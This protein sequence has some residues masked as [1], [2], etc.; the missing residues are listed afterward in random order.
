M[1]SDGSVGILDPQEQIYPGKAG[2]K[3]ELDWF[4]TEPQYSGHTSCFL[5]YFN[6]DGS[7]TY[8]GTIFRFPLR[9]RESN[10]QIKPDGLYDTT[11]VLKTLFE[12]L[13]LEASNIL[14]FLK[15]V[16]SIQLFKKQGKHT[17]R[18]FSV[19]IPGDYVEGVALC[20]RQLSD[21]VTDRK[22]QQNIKV[23]INVFPI[24]NSDCQQNKV[25][26]VLNM[27]GFPLSPSNFSKFYQDRKLDYLP[28][29]G[30][31][32]ETGVLESD[33]NKSI[34]LSFQYDW[35][36]ED[37]L[38]FINRILPDLKFRFRVPNRHQ[39][40]VASGKLFCF[41]P[42]PELSHLPVNF[43]G[44]FA[45][46]NN[47]RGIKWPSLDSD[48]T[49]S[50][51]NK[52]LVENIGVSAYA[53]FYRVLIHGFHHQTPETYHYRL[54]EKGNSLPNT[55]PSILVDQGLEKLAKS[56]IVY[57]TVLNEWIQVS[58]GLYHPTQYVNIIYNCSRT[59]T[60]INHL[61]EFLKLPLVPLPDTFSIALNEIDTI[62]SLIDGKR[63]TPKAIREILKQSSD[64]KRL[65]DYF[66][67]NLK[68]DTLVILAFIL[69]DLK[70][71]YTHSNV[72]LE[73][74]PLLVT[75]SSKI[76]KFSQNSKDH[77]YIYQRDLHFIDLFPGLEDSFVSTDVPDEI[78]SRLLAISQ[79]CSFNLK[80]ISNCLRTDSS[81]LM[82][83]FQQS[84]NSTFPHT[85]RT[86]RWEPEASRFNLEWIKSVWSFLSSADKLVRS[87]ETLPLLPKENLSS[88]IN[89]LL[90]IHP[91]NN[92]N[93]Y[94][95]YSGDKGYSE[96]ENALVASGAIFIYHNNRLVECLE[97]LI[98]KQL[99]NGFLVLLEKNPSIL[100]KFISQLNSTKN[101]SLNTNIIVDVLNRQSPYVVSQKS[102]IIKKLPIFT[103]MSG[104]N[105]PLSSSCV[106]VP[107]SIGLPTGI[108]YP[109][110]F[111]SPDYSSLNCLYDSLVVLSLDISSFVIQHL[112]TFMQSLSVHKNY[113]HHWLLG[114]WLLDRMGNLSPDVIVFLRGFE[115]IV[116]NSQ[117]SISQCGD[118]KKPDQLFYPDDYI[119]SHILPARSRFFPHRE[120]QSYSHTAKHSQ[121]F[122]TSSQI[123]N[124]QIFK[125]IVETAVGNF[126]L[127]EEDWKNRFS[128][129]LELLRISTIGI[130]CVSNSLHSSAIALP[131]CERPEAYPRSLPFIGVRKLCKLKAVVFCT[132]EEV[133]LIA[134]VEQC[135]PLFTSPY[136]HNS[137]ANFKS[138]LTQL[139]CRTSL[140]GEMLV[141]QLNK[142][143]QTTP[144]RSDSQKLHTL[145]NAIY[146]HPRMLNLKPSIVSNFVYVKTRNMFVDAT[147]IVFN[148]DFSLE[149]HY[150]SFEK[151]NYSAEAG[152]LFLEQGAS[153]AISPHQ[154]NG[155]LQGLYNAQAVVSTKDKGIV[156]K[157]I[158]YLFNFEEELSL[159]R[160][161]LLG[162]DYLVHLATE[163]VFYSSGNSGNK[164]EVEKDNK[165]YFVVHSKIPCTV[166]TKFGAKSLKLT[167]LGNTGSIFECVGQY[168]HLTTRLRSILKDY[169]SSI[170]V[171]KELIQNADDAKANYV[172]VLIDYCTFPAMSL[173]EPS[174]KLWQGP[175]LYF[176]N[177]AEFTDKDFLNILQI[178]GETKLH[179]KCKIGKFGLGFNT[180]YHLTDLP[181]FVS[182]RYIY[183]LDPHRKYLVDENCPPGIRVD[184]IENNKS[185]L[186]YRDQFN[187]FNF[188]LFNCNVFNG[189]PFKGTLFRLPFRSHHVHS[190][191]SS[192]VYDNSDITQLIVSIKEQTESNILFLQH[193]SRIEVYQRTKCLKE[194]QLLIVSKK[195]ETNPFPKHETFISQNLNHFDK[196]VS[197]SAVS[198]VF[199]FQ[200][201]SIAKNKTKRRYFVSYSTGTKQCAE[202]LREI[203]NRDYTPAASIAIPEDTAL[204]DYADT[205]CRSNIYC[206]LPLPI[207]S[208][209]PM[210][211]NGCFAL[212][213]SRRA[214]AC[215]EDD[216]ERTK[217]NQALISDALV[218]ALINLLNQVKGK[219]TQKTISQFYSLW[220]LHQQQP[221]AW[222]EFPHSFAM[223]LIELNIPLFHYELIANK[224]ISYQDA[225][226]FQSE[227][228]YPKNEMDDFFILI[229]NLVCREFSTYL[230]QLPD[231]VQTS[232]LF[233]SFFKDS[234]KVYSL[235]EICK[236]FVFP[237]FHTLSLEQIKLVLTALLPI[238]QIA[239]QNWI[240]KLF[241]ETNCIPCGSHSNYTLL[242]PSSVVSSHSELARLYIPTDKRTIHPDLVG[243]FAKKSVHFKV[244][245]SLDMI[246]SVLPVED[247]IERCKCQEYFV[248]P[249]RKEHC[250]ILL[251]YLNSKCMEPPKSYKIGELNRLKQE[252]LGIHFIPVWRD[253]LLIQL[254][255]Q[256]FI[257]FSTPTKCF[258]YNSRYF[259]PPEYYSAIQE[260]DITRLNTFLN[261]YTS[262]NAITIDMIISLL[263]CLQQ[264]E[265][266][267]FQLN[268]Q[269]EL[270]T[271]AAKIYAE[272][273]NLWKILSPNCKLSSLKWIWH[274]DTGCF[275]HVSSMVTSNKY[276]PYK[277][278]FLSTFPYKQKKDFQIGNTDKFLKELGI[279][280]D[281]N[282]ERA[283]YVLSQIAS[284]HNNTINS[285]ALR[286]LIIEI[287]NSFF[288][289]PENS[290]TT[291]QPV[292][293]SSDLRL[294][295]PSDLRI[296]DMPWRKGGKK[297][298]SRGIP[299]SLV[300]YKIHPTA[301]FNLGASSIRSDCFTRE[302]FTQSDFGQHEDIADRINSLKRGFPCGTTILK[303]LLQNAEDAGASE[304]AFVLDLK[305]YS[306]QTNSLCFSKQE[307]PHWHKYQQCP[308]LLVYNNS[309]FSKQD[310]KGIQELGL[311]GKTD[312]HTIGKF[313]L[314]F[315]AVYHLTDSPC[316]LTR[317]N[318]DKI[319]SFCIF[320]PFRKYL[321]LDPGDRPGIH[322]NFESTKIDEFP[323]QFSPYRLESLNQTGVNSFPS[324][325]KGDY[326]LF[327][328]PLTNIKTAE[329]IL[330]AFQL[331]SANMNLFLE[332]IKHISIYKRDKNGHIS[333]LG[334][335]DLSI[336]PSGKVSPLNSLQCNFMK[337]INISVREVVI[338]QDTPKTNLG[339][340][341]RPVSPDRYSWL[342]LTHTG[343]IEE[344][345]KC[346]PDIKKYKS[347]YEKE[348][349]AH[350]VYGGI[351][352]R[353]PGDTSTVLGSCLYSY[354]PIGDD[355]AM[356]F[357]VV[358]NAP[359]ILEPER[360]HIRFKDIRG[361]KT[362]KKEWEDTWHSAIIEHVLT[363]LFVS[364]VLYLVNKNAT[365]L[366]TTGYNDSAY[367]S[368]Y[369]SLYPD[370]KKLVGS[371]EIYNNFLYALCKHF[372]S[373]LYK[374]N[375]RVLIDQTYKELYSLRGGMEGVFP[376]ISGSLTR[377]TTL[378]SNYLATICADSTRPTKLPR[379][380]EI[381][382]K[383]HTTLMKIQFR[384]AIA[385]D[386]VEA[387]F[388]SFS[389]N[390]QRLNQKYLLQF[391]NSNI[392]KFYNKNVSNSLLNL[393]DIELLLTYLLKAN[394]DVLNSYHTIPLK[395]DYKGRFCCFTKQECT[396]TSEYADLLPDCAGRF[397]YP[398]FTL[399]CTAQLSKHGFIQQLDV[400]FLSLKLCK[401]EFNMKE[402]CLFWQF[403]MASSFQSHE[404]IK[405]FG[406]F[407]CIPVKTKSTECLT[408]ISHLP[409][410]LGP[411]GPISQLLLLSSLKKLNCF[412]L[413]LNQFN[414]CR[415]IK[416]DTER[417]G[418]YL[419]QLTIGNITYP[420]FMSAVKLSTIVLES[421][422]FSVSEANELTHLFALSEISY[423][424]Y[425]E[426]Q[427]ISKLK[428]FE[429]QQL[430]LFSVS[431]FRNCF[432]NNSGINFGPLL[433]AILTRS[434]LTI[435]RATHKLDA[436][437]QRIT[438]VLRINMIAEEAIFL[439][440]VIPHFAELDIKEQQ[441][442]LNY[443]ES[444]SKPYK[445]QFIARLRLVKFIRNPTSGV[446]SPVSE[447]YC[448]AVVLFRIFFTQQ[449]LP[450]DWSHTDEKFYRLLCAVGLHNRADLESILMA[451]QM[452]A[453]NTIVLQSDQKKLPL[454]SLVTL[455]KNN[456]SLSIGN[457]SL[458][459]TLS[460]V[461]FLP[462]WKCLPNTN[463]NEEHISSFNEAE[464]STYNYTCCTAAYIHDTLVTQIDSTQIRSYLRIRDRP[465]NQTVIK[466]LEIICQYFPQLST[467]HSRVIK[468]F[469]LKTYKFLQEH[470]DQ[471]SVAKFQTMQCIL[472]K[473]RL[474]YPRNIVFSLDTILMDYLFKVPDAF[475]EYHSF[476]KL[477]GVAN[478]P[479][480]LHYAAVLSDISRDMSLNNEKRK[481]ISRST[482]N[483]FICSLR[484]AEESGAVVVLDLA[485]TMV[486]SSEFEIVKLNQVVY[487][488][489]TRLKIHLGYFS[490]L[491]SLKFLLELTPNSLGS[492]KP[493]VAFDVTQLSAIIQEN[494][495][496]SLVRAPTPTKFKNESIKLSQILKSIEF[497]KGLIRI[498]YHSTKAKGKGNLGFIR[499]NSN[500]LVKNILTEPRIVHDPQFSTVFQI[501]Q[502]LT[503]TLLDSISLQI[504][505][506]RSNSVFD[507]DDIYYCYIEESVLYAKG[508]STAGV[509]FFNDLTYALNL[510]LGNLFSDML[511]ALQLCLSCRNP[512][513]IPRNLD[514]FDI[515][516]C[517]FIDDI[518]LPQSISVPTVVL[519]SPAPVIRRAAPISGIFNISGVNR[520][521]LFQ[522]INRPL[523]PPVP[524]SPDT[525]ISVIQSPRGTLSAQDRFTAKLWIRTAQCDLLAAKKL[526]CEDDRNAIFPPHSCANCFECAMKTCIAIL[527]INRLQEANISCQRNLDILLDT[528]KRFFPSGSDS[529]KK[530]SCNCV[531]LMN[532]DEN[533]KNPLM[534]PGISCCLPMEQ[535]S[536]ATAKEAVASASD[537]LEIV[538]SQ[539]P[540]FNELMF[541]EGD[542]VWE[543]P[544][545]RSLIMSQLENCKL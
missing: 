30:I 31:A 142:I 336:T 25:M 507:K 7:Y 381:E 268:L 409:G 304:I 262:N 379:L 34:E 343:S 212:D 154:L 109:I 171:Y 269:T 303:E 100:N 316:L 390:L 420:A 421:V 485:N 72:Y 22:F 319:I 307:Q 429:S 207:K 135:V 452:I 493:P 206:Y 410:I 156:I 254:E 512:L 3:I 152:E 467:N 198:P 227:Q 359:F 174:M 439:D 64:N 104:N 427:I 219:Y 167:L 45:L 286:D 36:G 358:I 543:R 500:G 405:T 310:L 122:L 422:N 446:E 488:D 123:P 348:K 138:I 57:S 306:S 179:D 146:A 411:S 374:C 540:V 130:S 94:I 38:S 515:S 432:I 26:L 294:C 220:P 106:R 2:K 96:L 351:A 380:S 490:D 302:H 29:I 450:P 151:L 53:I 159:D 251:N 243:L 35:N 308:S 225:N 433:I 194:L 172:R 525:P 217:W 224:W 521:T 89:L 473:D 91:P 270:S 216:S 39:L 539:F 274:P 1:L 544:T 267:I 177:D 51:W 383:L 320:D 463:R 98:V 144:E 186:E 435:F 443:V 361:D 347:T 239:G 444:S 498:Y 184:F 79:A 309:A 196:L 241:S 140:T 81:L 127:R 345:E 97:S 342:L 42:T 266:K 139:G 451:A 441:G 398:G 290:C 201:I 163:C 339:K 231:A 511:F 317:R 168:E 55:L 190:L 9:T 533:A 366:Q 58:Q 253:P 47:R 85:N 291:T 69:S 484:K 384:L 527:Y 285:N 428:I 458:L 232:E 193:V 538:R 83:L 260:V 279:K 115:W 11:R 33:L 21:H 153:S 417:L 494:L 372:Y 78:H 125:E 407:A 293:L 531:A 496:P 434:S 468:D 272:L 197:G 155:I 257:E 248:N 67:K 393:E 322:L 445:P 258:P 453:N 492:C 218:N 312:K 477:V 37:I 68:N 482:F 518:Q 250:M 150:Y 60:A 502:N 330:S 465:V 534:I 299:N 15:N 483:L 526:I 363:P 357:P 102:S 506:K 50:N 70:H 418:S 187:V 305:D 162:E 75:A 213:Q 18:I 314:G 321:K 326:T 311:G 182:G 536:V 211:I 440:Y 111:L 183:M 158:D 352:V 114:K 80:D 395:I 54:F 476:L 333:I 404:L 415:T 385:P 362:V 295:R 545:D 222:K 331:Q 313:G 277:S 215:T 121:L 287:T 480:Y 292:L 93:S 283:C 247:V 430:K 273:F 28:W 392:T 402:C 478:N 77:L 112:A 297:S 17:T 32:M 192:K 134:S 48:D 228:Y 401:K 334:T 236:T 300:H 73:N 542:R 117:L 126:S 137:P 495:K 27:I 426:I 242:L 180:V 63:I 288:N 466:H 170:D 284:E 261:I 43:H 524:R 360:Q 223:R 328:I 504:T 354:L 391:L 24:S 240:K 529:Y 499:I 516:V 281:I 202:F 532:F 399:T 541:G 87:L 62:K 116:D 160:Y 40:P 289:D 234:A 397:L 181:S 278:K 491:S 424:P 382:N 365:V 107:A 350:Q 133:P 528:V 400:E 370:M 271:R 344:L 329:D 199:Y 233:Q 509:N 147:G 8:D 474:F 214:I 252:L 178:F 367:Y 340:R 6:C 301:A 66:R 353:I 108:N 204:R 185:I 145:L 276:L 341:T 113:A 169:E 425:E 514:S 448:P 315:N 210:F 255:L 141:R 461:R 503:I 481:E 282:S 195:E 470:C 325:T 406:E 175:A 189:K 256:S 335:M 245:K 475:N 20:Y 263:D 166:A 464:L 408:L 52:L 264:N 416:L 209:Y 71:P 238:V 5:S 519:P 74:V 265:N 226:F 208:P 389:L 61:L 14:L 88:K 489:N 298:L 143:S 505:N 431:E 235:Q 454:S 249:R 59:E 120:Y 173:I 349:L 124:Q 13:K 486:L 472:Y 132:E 131:L 355:R 221:V 118:Y 364:L 191:I 510:Y 44:Y 412:E 469:F 246:E 230:I 459:K 149:P 205:T 535:I 327:R 460:T 10:S 19:G 237:K 375:E 332:H 161:Y 462:V 537:I 455:V 105:I 41:L 92:A 449:L 530:F 513:D 188:S 103:N 522:I 414:T 280:A 200:I 318:S 447:F 259:I 16:K 176:Y 517:P 86:N 386:H 413:S 457:I 323:D 396:Y 394:S 164:T 387:S 56:E 403:I 378:L 324:L 437:I 436:L 438:S 4:F 82:R 46:S 157:I 12:P 479:T 371:N 110:S 501:I 523:P 373:L 442:I 368:W 296:D 456:F 119:M 148:L 90:P 129:L 346:C 165:M 376:D 520:G 369:Y 388:R 275:C 84:L 23:T 377:N 101:K 423:L 244:M 356:H 487:I 508:G 338:H 95:L 76:L 419:K 49:D 497:A 471:A 136:L 65:I 203:K 99:P 128:S 337:N 229:R